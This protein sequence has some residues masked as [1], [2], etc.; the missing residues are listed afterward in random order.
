MLF[1]HTFCLRIYVNH[2]GNS[3]LI[4]ALKSVEK[5]QSYIV[6]DIFQSGHT[7]KVHIHTQRNSEGLFSSNKHRNFHKNMTSF[8]L[9]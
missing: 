5:I 3:T 1:S 2:N 9:F 4:L 8:Q 7:T 6:Q